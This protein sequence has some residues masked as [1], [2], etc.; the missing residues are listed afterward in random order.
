MRAGKW[1][2][3][4]VLSVLVLVVSACAAP[5]IDVTDLALDLETQEVALP[6]GTL[7]AEAVPDAFVAAVDADLYIAIIPREADDG[8]G[9]QEVAA[10]LC[11][12]LEVVAW[13]TGQVSDGQGT[14]TAGDI[15]VEIE[16]LADEVRGTV[17]VAG[18]APEA[19]TA[20]EVEGDAGF[21]QADAE[22]DGTRHLG[23]WI[24]LEDGSQR[25]AI[26]FYHEDDE[27]QDITYLFRR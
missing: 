25:G 22:V 13:L 20:V 16:S 17:T 3:L 26:V 11:D 21:Y 27:Q 19:F 4:G 15:Q 9:V 10:Y 7:R 1:I 8:D 24:V 12:G 2:W 23:R 6:A 14:L 18:G 5:E